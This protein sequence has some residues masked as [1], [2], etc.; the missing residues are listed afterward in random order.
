[1]ALPD[2]ALPRQ[3]AAMDER[4]PAGVRERLKGSRLF[5][6][7]VTPVY[8]ALQRRRPSAGSVTRRNSRR[9][10]EKLFRSD[11]LLAGYLS[12][13]RTRFYDEIATIAASFDPASVLDVGCGSGELI[14][15]IAARLPGERALAGIDYT[16]SGIA[17][18]RA[19]F[20]A[21]NWIVADLYRLDP[22]DLFG[23]ARFDLV[24]CT[25]V[26]EHL[27]D[28]HTALDRLA[29]FC[30]TRGRVVVTVPDGAIDDW[31]GHVNFWTE[32]ELARLLEP[33][34]LEEIR[35]VDEDQTLLAIFAPRR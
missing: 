10:Y 2:P 6:R 15:S 14:R 17:R 4:A 5:G 28:P 11:R 30:A 24:A 1:M 19:A 29:A 18:A 35:R 25:E 7:A 32:E 34:G 20:P 26:L 21:A 9:A 31:P 8:R 3:D 27:E 13:S 22:E 12:P 16:R 33:R 23:G